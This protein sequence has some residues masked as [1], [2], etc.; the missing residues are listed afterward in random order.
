MKILKIKSLT[1]L[2]A[3]ILLISNFAQSRTYDDI[4]P[5]KTSFGY[6]PVGKSSKF[7]YWMAP[8]RNNPAKD[9]LVFWFQGGP[10]GSSL[11]GLFFEMGPF[12]I[13]EAGD[14]HATL[15][16][17]AWNNNANMVFIDNPIGVGFSV[18]ETEDLPHNAGD[19]GNQFYEFLTN[20]LNMPEHKAFKGRALYITGESFAG[21]WIPYISNKIY[22]ANNPDMNL[23]GV[24]IGNA[25]MTT[26]ETYRWYPEMA[27]QNREYTKM[28]D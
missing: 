25:W 21:H 8:S 11:F 1:F 13:K 27:N 12:Y 23:K 6:V 22:L 7:F 19:I 3:S 4:F 28:D 2:L 16:T 15:R 9:P 18:G 20:F 26:S 24:M 10:G 5:E 17:N 14:D